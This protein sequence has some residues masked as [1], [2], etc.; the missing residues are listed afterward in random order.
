VRIVGGKLRGIQLSPIKNVGVKTNLRPTT[1]RIRENIFNIIL[2]GRFGN[3]LKHKRVL[4]LF[5]GTGV[6]GIEAI[7]RGAEHATL[8]EK[9]PQVFKLIQNNIKITNIA[10]Q[11]TLIN[12]NALNLGICEV[13]PYDLV[14][15][16]A[17]Y[18]KTLG[19]NALEKVFLNGWLARNALV[20]WEDSRS[21][22]VP[23][24]LIYLDEKKYGNTVL[25]FLNVP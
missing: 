25:T 5:S 13:K 23:K 1:D 7:S 12:A 11:V 3:Q 19:K 16:D 4:D 8:V 6:L 15:L 18:E 2:G 22:E 21:A 9:N 24:D 10:D 17:P 14:F 20:V